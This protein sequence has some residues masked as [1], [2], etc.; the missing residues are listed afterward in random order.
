MY[1]YNRTGVGFSWGTFPARTSST[2][3]TIRTLSAPVKAMKALQWWRV[4][5]RGRYRLSFLLDALGD[6]GIGIA[7]SS[8]RT[9]TVGETRCQPVIRSTEWGITETTDEEGNPLIVGS[10]DPTNIWKKN[11]RYYILTAICWC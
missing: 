2:G 11:G 7:K 1:L 4:R 9:T 3:D 10:A 6:K 8:E 5:R